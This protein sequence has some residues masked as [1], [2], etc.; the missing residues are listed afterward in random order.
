MIDLTFETTGDTAVIQ[1]LDALERV[2]DTTPPVDAIK[3]VALPILQFYPPERAGQKYRRSE[4]LK[5]GWAAS[6][7]GDVIAL[8]N[9]VDYAGLVYS[10]ADQ[11]DVH[12]DRWPTQTQLRTQLEGPMTSVYREWVGRLVQG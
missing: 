9:T 1:R 7:S 12:K 10:D 11:A 3:E 5:R 6:P 8:E 2:I 4:D